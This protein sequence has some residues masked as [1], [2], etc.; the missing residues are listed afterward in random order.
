MTIQ[1][2]AISSKKEMKT[3][4]RFGNRL[5]KGNRYYVPSM[6]LD[7]KLSIVASMMRLMMLN[8]TRSCI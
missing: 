3:F 7:V 1:V 4:V 2:K 6:P 8:I 5:Y